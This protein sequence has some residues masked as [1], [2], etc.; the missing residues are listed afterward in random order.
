[1][2]PD[3]PIALHNGDALTFGKAVGKGPYLVSPV[4]ANVMPIYDTE[5]VLSPPVSQPVISLVDSHTL[6]ATPINTKERAKAPDPPPPPPPNPGRYGLFGLPPTPS[7]RSPPTSSASEG[8]FISHSRPQA[9][10]ST[11]VRFHPESYYPRSRQRD[12]GGCH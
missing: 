9:F 1:M 10:Y 2:V 8:G 3:V 6:P 4:T 5:A 7:P 11:M 12:H